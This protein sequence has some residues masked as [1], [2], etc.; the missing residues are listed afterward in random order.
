MEKGVMLGYAVRDAKKR[1]E[2]DVNTEVLYTALFC[3][4]LL[5]VFKKCLKVETILENNRRL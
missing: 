4:N 2:I 1:T 5:L 3:T